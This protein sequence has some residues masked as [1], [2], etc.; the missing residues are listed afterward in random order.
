MNKREISAADIIGVVF[1]VIGVL[2]A[3]IG[4]ACQLNIEKIAN[5]PSAQGDVR[6]LPVVFGGIGVV[7]LVIGL[8]FVGFTVRKRKT[9]A[10][11]LEQGYYIVGRVADIRPDYSVQVNGRNPYFLECHYEDPVTGK[12]HI[13]RSGNLF[14]RPDELLGSDVRIYVDADDYAKY[15]V[16]IQALT[17]NV[18]YH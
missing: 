7:F 14:Y 12:M 16:D 18:V 10:A 5:S 8:I 13:F 2:F 4:G 11:L 17:E 3:G 1:T 9:K 6:I 15:Y